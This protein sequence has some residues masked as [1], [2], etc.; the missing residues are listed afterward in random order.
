MTAVHLPNKRLANY[1]PTAYPTS[2]AVTASQTFRYAYRRADKG[3]AASS[4]DGRT[5]VF[6]AG[7]LSRR[8]SFPLL[9]SHWLSFPLAGSGVP[10][11]PGNLR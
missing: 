10:G 8:L 11:R 2:R 3:A 6:P 5:F 9:L 4:G 7:C 1:R